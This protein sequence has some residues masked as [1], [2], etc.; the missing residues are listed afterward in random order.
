MTALWREK[1]IY[2]IPVFPKNNYLRFQIFV[3]TGFIPE[4]LRFDQVP[5]TSE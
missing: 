1:R 2:R 5:T 4:Q 3:V